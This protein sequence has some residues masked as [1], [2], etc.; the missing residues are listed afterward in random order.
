MLHMTV[1]WHLLVT[2]QRRVY[3]R[4]KEDA[5]IIRLV[6]NVT[7]C[8]L[9]IFRW[10][11]G[12]LKLWRASAEIFWMY[13]DLFKPSSN[14]T[15]VWLLSSVWLVSPAERQGWRWLCF[16]KTACILVF[17]YRMI[18]SHISTFVIRRLF[19]WRSSKH[20]E[21]VPA[22]PGDVVR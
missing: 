1:H 9:I 12:K 11:Y 21:T 14:Q 3:I 22:R 16:I 10:S 4:R 5:V 15:N 17:S 2:L 19:I 20:L 6:N 7:N 13:V 8:F 18:N